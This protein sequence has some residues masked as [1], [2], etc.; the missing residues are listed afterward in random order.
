M[1]KKLTFW[2]GKVMSNLLELSTNLGSLLYKM[3]TSDQ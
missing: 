3:E 2:S 1:Y